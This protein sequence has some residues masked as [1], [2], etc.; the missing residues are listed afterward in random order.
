M[1]QMTALAEIVGRVYDRR[2][3]RSSY[4]GASRSCSVGAVPRRSAY[5]IVKLLLQDALDKLD[6]KVID[7]A[8]RTV[9]SALETNDVNHNEVFVKDALC[10]ALN[11]LLL[12]IL[13]DDSRIRVSFETAIILIV[14]SESGVKMF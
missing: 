13:E 3:S 8:G 14:I 1:E 5:Q 11:S 7:L 2:L 4:K 10:S 12:S 6:N 9:V